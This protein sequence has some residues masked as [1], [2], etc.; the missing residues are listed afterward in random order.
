MRQKILQ[1]TT[2]ASALKN[3][4]K[5]LFVLI[6]MNAFMAIVSNIV[7]WH[8][9]MSVEWYLRPF[10]PICALYPLALAIWYTVF[11]FRK[12]VPGWYTT[13][14][15]IGIVSYGIM[16]YIYY[17]VTMAWQ[18]IEWRLPGN[19]LW[20]TIYALQSF[21]IL[22]ELKK[23]PWYQFSLIVGY[24]LFKDYADRFLGTFIDTREPDYPEALKNFFGISI[25]TLHLTL[26]VVTRKFEALKIFLTQQFSA[27]KETKIYSKTSSAR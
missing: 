5:T 24:F 11:Y 6:V 18:G 10:T 4:R 9:L 25:L 7:D 17:P 20:V 27:S 8:W 14:V 26:F 15:F 19:M 1:L 22:S 21:I 23:I 12:K 3:D 13:F 2:W 16:A